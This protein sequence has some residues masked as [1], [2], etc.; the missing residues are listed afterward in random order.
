MNLNASRLGT[1]VVQA[2]FSATRMMKVVEDSHNSKVAEALLTKQC[3]EKASAKAIDSAMEEIQGAHTPADMWWVERE[4]LPTSP[5][6]GP[7][8][9]V[10]LWS[11]TILSLNI[12][13]SLNLLKE[14]MAQVM[15]LPE[16]VRQRKNSVSP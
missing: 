4:S 16:W 10:P 2:C 11:S 3:L 1:A 12:P 6:R 13:K 5:A 15:S 7:R 9:T 14:M 8:P